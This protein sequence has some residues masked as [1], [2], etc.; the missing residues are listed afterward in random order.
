MDNVVDLV[1]QEFYTSLRDHKSGNT[2]DHIWDTV[3]VRGKEVQI[4][5]ALCY[6]AK[7]ASLFW[8]M[9]PPWEDALVARRWEDCSRINK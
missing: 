6:F 8:Q 2:K 5:V 7:K 1:V 4:I 9:D 3:L